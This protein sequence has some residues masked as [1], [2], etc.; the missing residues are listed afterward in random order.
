MNLLRG[1]FALVS[2]GLL[3]GPS[4]AQNADHDWSM[5]NRDVIGTRHNSA[6]MAIGVANA[7]QLEEKWRFPAAG[8]KEQIG[9]IH[10]TPVVVSGYVYFGTATDS[11]VYKLAPNGTLKWV[12]RNPS[13]TPDLA[14]K[15]ASVLNPNARF[16]SSADGIHGS[17]LVTDDTVYFG[18][19]GG[20]FYALDRASGKERW[21]INSRA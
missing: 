17:A 10:A 16:S 7:G 3:V 21:K 14:T 18:D 13:R 12:Y 9:V 1:L 4:L 6:E 19:I 20:W 5:Y 15:V 11:A 8:A 2:T